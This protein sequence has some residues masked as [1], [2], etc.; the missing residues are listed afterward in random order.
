M[1]TRQWG[2]ALLFLL[3]F[4]GQLEGNAETAAPALPA[5]DLSG[6]E[7]DVRAV[8]R[9]ARE[10]LSQRLAA[11]GTGPQ[12][13]AAAL[14]SL[15]RLYQAHLFGAAAIACFGR[16]VALAPSEFQWH[17]HLGYARESGGH[18]PESAE[19]YG[20]ALALQ[21]RSA[22]TRLRLGQVLLQ[23][24]DLDAAVP[25]LQEAAQDPAL[26]P[27]A[28]Y[29]MGRLRYQQGDYD[30]ARDA[31]EQ[32]LV[33]QPQATRLHYPLALAYRAL[34]DTR[35]ARRHLALRG[36]AAPTFPDPLIDPLL[37]LSTGQRMLFH[38][39]MD[40]ANRRDFTAAAH[41]FREGLEL[42]P[43]NHA[44]R[45][46]LGRF[47]YLA[48]DRQGARQ[49]LLKVPRDARDAPLAGL[50]LGVLDQESGQPGAAMERYRAALERDPAHAGLHYYL[51]NALYRAGE[52]DAAVDHYA[53]AVRDS[54]DNV[55][56]RFWGILAAIRAGRSQQ[57]L[58][59]LLQAAAQQH[60]DNPSIGYFLAALLA[61]G[62]ER[63]LRDGDRA[64]ARAQQLY[65]RRPSL[66]HAELLAMA[67]A[68]SG[69]FAAAR[70]LQEQ[71]VEQAWA[72]Q[73]WE[74]LN[75]AKERLERYRQD[76]PCRTPWNE[77][78]LA[79]A[80]PPFNATKVFES[81]PASG[82]F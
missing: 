46:S 54:Q 65:R 42:V 40:A 68:E 47:L 39:G 45:V 61:A 6:L 69:D 64:L 58:L 51:A 57:E 4:G 70:S 81:Y 36:D 41:W 60:P 71:V 66:E 21:P 14:G 43:G 77:S 26:R 13:A 31:L 19:A 23:S 80:V 56:A 76:L 28:L 27:V 75:G 8:L 62:S 1:T 78:E 74:L 33:L 25:L 79:W 72:A 20:G 38:L 29:E 59:R 12:E 55:G 22:V 17:Y 2:W 44:A 37:E 10:T 11:P 24:G 3:L 16:A 30:A 48:G 7:P 49:A 52:F 32:A 73:R 5:P 15:G 53:A 35:Q 9:T 67:K 18:L 63:E 50:L 34:G 82:S